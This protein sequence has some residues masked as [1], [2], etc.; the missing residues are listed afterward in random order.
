MFGFIKKILAV[1]VTDIINAPSHI[2]YIYLSNHN[3]RLNVL[4]LIY[5]RR[6]TKRLRHY[7][8][9]VNLDR[10]T[11]SCNTLNDLSN[12]R[13]CVQKKAEDLNLN[14]FNMITGINESKILT[15][16]VSC[17]FKGKFDGRKCNSNQNWNNNNF[18]CKYK[19]LEEHHAREK[20]LESFYVYL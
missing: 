1:L 17:E 10:C 5:V 11:E 14:V 6:Y 16:H 19:N 20:D 12:N 4:L 9:A 2:K 13:V 8:F 15:K 3:A 18:R 7:L